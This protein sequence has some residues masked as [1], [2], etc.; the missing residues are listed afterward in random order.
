MCRVTREKPRTL[1]TTKGSQYVRGLRPH[2]AVQPTFAKRRQEHGARVDICAFRKRKAQ[3]IFSSHQNDAGDGC[4]T[5]VPPALLIRFVLNPVASCF[6]SEKL[7]QSKNPSHMGH[8]WP[9][10]SKLEP[11]LWLRFIHNPVRS[12]VHIYS[13]SCHTH[14]HPISVC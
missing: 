4:G 14:N 3:S 5:N 6:R 2:S 12:S 10:R 9:I 13:A 7:T 1:N 8:L 11:R